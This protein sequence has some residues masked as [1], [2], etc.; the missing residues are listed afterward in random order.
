[1]ETPDTRVVAE[2]AAASA[3]VT[4]APSQREKFGVGVKDA[5]FSSIGQ[6]THTKL[7][8]PLYHPLPKPNKPN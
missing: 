2:N 4:D 1:M 7:T 3:A 6:H 8:V 5:T